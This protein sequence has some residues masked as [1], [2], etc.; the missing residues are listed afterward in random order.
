MQDIRSHPD[1]HIRLSTAA[2]ADILWWHM[3]ACCGL[4]RLTLMYILFSD[5]SGSFHN[6]FTFSG[7]QLLPI[8]IGP[9]V[10]D[11]VT[12]AFFQCLHQA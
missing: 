7:L 2:R 10:T 12:D 6:G 4:H 5:A 1:H 9:P 8:A 3:F 11:P